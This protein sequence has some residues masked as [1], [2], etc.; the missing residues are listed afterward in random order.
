MNRLVVATAC[1][2]E[3]LLNRLVRSVVHKIIDLLA[4]EKWIVDINF[5]G[6]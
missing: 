6:K 1:V 5:I 2:R 3:C 4:V